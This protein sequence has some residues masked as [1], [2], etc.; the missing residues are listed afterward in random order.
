MVG[1]DLEAL[2]GRDVDILTVGLKQRDWRSD[3]GRVAAGY[4]PPNRSGFCP[5]M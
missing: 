5:R 3:L 2:S 4:L 1:T